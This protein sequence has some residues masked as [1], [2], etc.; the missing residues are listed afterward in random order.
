MSTSLIMSEKKVDSHRFVPMGFLV[1]W[2]A[3]QKLPPTPVP[4][5]KLW[6]QFSLQDLNKTLELS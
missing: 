5:K 2:F 1:R 3:S 4:V 6:L